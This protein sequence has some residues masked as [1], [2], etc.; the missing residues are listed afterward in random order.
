MLNAFGASVEQLVRR[1]AVLRDFDPMVQA[2]LGR[3]MANA[4]VRIRTGVVPAALTRSHDGTLELAAE[5]G[6]RFGPY[7][8][9][10]WAIGREPAKTGT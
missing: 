8:A 6:S 1:D 10:I 7:D 2:A 5:G 3:E 9:V 4:G